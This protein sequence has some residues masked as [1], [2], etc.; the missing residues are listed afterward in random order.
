MEP[1]LDNIMVKKYPDYKD[2]GVEW[3]GEIPSHWKIKKMKFLA[4][5][6][7]GKLP[8]KIV[9][10]NESNLPPYMSMEY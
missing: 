3:L 10:A 5:I 1:I 6:H 9:S 8:S 7:K 2:S 4:E